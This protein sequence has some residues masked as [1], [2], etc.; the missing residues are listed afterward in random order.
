[1]GRTGLSDEKQFQ[2]AKA[3]GRALL[4]CNISDSV[5]LANGCMRSGEAFAGV[6]LSEQLPFREFLR[7]TARLMQERRQEYLVNSILWL[8]EFK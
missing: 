5:S 6:V 4:T 7:R 1:L 2:F 3:Q 8:N